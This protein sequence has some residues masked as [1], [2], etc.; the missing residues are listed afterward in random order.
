MK[1]NKCPK[2]LNLYCLVTAVSVRQ[3]MSIALHQDSFKVSI[4][5][6]LKDVLSI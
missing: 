5:P 3:L 2:L 6:H 1:F 4:L